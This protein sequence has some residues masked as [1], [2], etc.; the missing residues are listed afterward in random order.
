MQNENLQTLGQAQALRSV[1][2]NRK[3]RQRGKLFHGVPWPSIDYSKNEAMQKHKHLKELY[4]PIL[5][6]SS[7]WSQ[8]LR[9]PKSYIL[10]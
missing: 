1:P 7:T 4:R 3:T 6:V 2:M 8:M 9:E 10:L 5:T